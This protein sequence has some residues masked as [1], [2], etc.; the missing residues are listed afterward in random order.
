MRKIPALVALA[1][2]AIASVVSV[3]AAVADPRPNGNCYS[4]PCP[5][6]NCDD[7]P[8]PAPYPVMRA[9]IGGTNAEFALKVV[10]PSPYLLRLVEV[11]IASTAKLPGGI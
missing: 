7:P 3:S 6:G 1:A 5:G 9:S 11:G 10:V 2:L 8:V 4:D